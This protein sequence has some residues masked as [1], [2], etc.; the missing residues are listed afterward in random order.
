MRFPANDSTVNKKQVSSRLPVCCTLIF[1]FGAH[2]EFPMSTIDWIGAYCFLSPFSPFIFPVVMSPLLCHRW[3]SISVANDCTGEQSLNAA[4]AS[5]LQGSH[6]R[7]AWT[8]LKSSLADSLH[9]Q[10]SQLAV[11]FIPER[12]IKGET[13]G[14]RSTVSS[15]S[16]IS[17][18]CRGQRRLQSSFQ[19]FPKSTTYRGPVWVSSPCCRVTVGS[20]FLSFH[21]IFCSYH[22]NALR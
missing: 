12:H 10:P 15:A 8:A 20:F 21:F 6:W 2:A 1:E 11:W 5:I 22:L 13:E 7:W 14:E 3:A 19:V 9:D 18:R 16:K 4:L 17:L